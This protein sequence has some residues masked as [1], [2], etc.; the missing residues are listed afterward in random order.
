MDEKER[1]MIGRGSDRKRLRRDR[2]LALDEAGLDWTWR[3][4]SDLSR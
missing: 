4:L 2:I 3:I 1:G